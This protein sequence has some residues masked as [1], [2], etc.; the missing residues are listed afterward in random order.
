MNPVE[1]CQSLESMKEAENLTGIT[2]SLQEAHL[3]VV[4][5]ALK[6]SQVRSLKLC[7]HSCD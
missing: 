2:L 4:A 7:I 6:L 5:A 3:S 1:S